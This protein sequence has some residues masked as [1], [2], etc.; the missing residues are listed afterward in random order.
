MTNKIRNLVV[1]FS[2]FSILCSCGY[3]EKIALVG[4]TLIDVSNFG[5]SNK[6]LKDVIIIIEG[7]KITH[8]GDRDSVKIPKKAR[9][10]NIRG[11][12]VLPGLIDGFASLDNQSY[13]NAYLYMGVTSI[14]GV[15]GFNF[16]PL[17]ES[18]IPGPKLFIFSAVGHWKITTS[19]LLEQIEECGKKGVKFLLLQY[20]LSPE[21]LK[22]AIAKA[23]EWEIATIGELG[24]TSYKEAL[25]FGID[26]FLHSGRYSIELAPEKMRNKVA[27]DPFGPPAMTYRKWLAQGNPSDETLI[28]YAKIL[29]TH[30]TALMPTLTIHCMDLPA[31]ENPWEEPVAAILDP[32]DIHLPVDK[33]TGKHKF[34][35]DLSELIEKVAK[36]VIRIEKEYCKAG[37]KYLAG[38]GTDKFGA[39]P[40]ISLHQEL[41]LLTMVG[42]NARQAIAAATSNFAE[43][44]GWN[45]V[46]QIKP[47]CKADILVVERNPVES[48]KNL[49]KIHMVVLEGKILDRDHLMK[50]N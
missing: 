15:Y 45:E 22:L 49:K 17:F 5:N 38:S 6:D 32:E 1:I 48:I 30:Q 25:E 24:S 36:N 29:G 35:S 9:I 16:S 34:D 7:K 10:V 2:F 21:Q 42:L 27:K 44:F 3:A 33:S 11:K 20:A 41:E 43:I 40:G 28:K 8:V 18:A 23:H 39:M 50:Q 14:V 12:F 26:A 37:A 13:A 31:L 19:E 4:G 47:G 46:G